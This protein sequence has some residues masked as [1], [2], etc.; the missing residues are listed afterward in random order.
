LFMASMSRSL[1][2]MELDGDSMV[3][4][5]KM[6]EGLKQRLRDVAVGPDGNLYVLTD[7]EAG[8]LLRISPGL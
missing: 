8:A 7:E 4:Q 1:V 3:H 5:E 2:R 6:L